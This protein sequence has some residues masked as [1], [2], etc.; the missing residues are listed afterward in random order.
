V[1]KETIIGIV[2]FLWPVKSSD[3]KELLGI[4]QRKLLY[5]QTVRIDCHLK[6]AFEFKTPP[7]NMQQ[8][9]QPH[10]IMQLGSNKVSLMV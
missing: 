2:S 10:K 4:L 7:T 1:Q 5:N 9:G 6:E 8:N 3:H